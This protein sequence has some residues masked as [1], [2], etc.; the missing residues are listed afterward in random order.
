MAQGKGWMA[1]PWL[2]FLFNQKKSFEVVVN[3]GRMDIQA[4]INKIP[5]PVSREGRAVK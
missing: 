5:F 3:R 2:L 1:V 4:K